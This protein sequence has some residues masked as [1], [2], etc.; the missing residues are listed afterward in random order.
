MKAIDL[1]L[2]VKWCD[3]NIGTSSPEKYGN[4]FSWGEVL[5]KNIYDWSTYKWYNES[6]SNFT[7]YCTKNVYGVIDKKLNLNLKM[8]WLL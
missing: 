1:G 8:M 6:N 7:K 4:Y 5:P 3:C 2:S